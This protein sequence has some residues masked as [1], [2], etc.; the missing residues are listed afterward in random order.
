[1]GE[2]DP[3]FIQDV[4]HR[5]KL[6]VSQAEGIPLIDLTALAGYSP[7]DGAVAA[8]AAAAIEGLVAEIGEACKKWGFF[9]VVNHGV[10]AEKRERIEREARE[11]FGQDL[12]EKKKVRK[13]ERK[14]MGYYEMEHTKNVRDWREVFDITVQEPTLVPASL[15]D[16]E[17]AVIEW[18]NQWPEY[19]PGLREACEEYTQEMEKLAYKLMGLIAQSL[20]LPANRFGEFFKDQTSYLRLV[21]YPPCPAPHLALGLGRHNDLGALAILAQDD[22]GG[23]EVKR[24]SD[25]EWVLV[26]PI[27][28]AFIIN[29]GCVMQ[30]WSNDMYESVEHR[31]M[32]N[33]EKERFS[34]PF[35]FNPSHYTM[36]QPLKE[37]TDEHNPPKYR[38]YSWG[39]FYVIRKGGN[40]KKLDVENIQIHHFRI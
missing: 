24:K 14:V 35:F 16:G 39:R 19:P 8:S 22:V 5:P 1:M 40:F 31:V 29:V 21:R 2:V 12:E 33:T 15:K 27:P 25:G 38:P 4:E 13:D 32:V 34:I 26:K 6:A 7:S 3:A 11:F 23:L 20:G 9:T 36:V 28:D 17:E 37:L 18:T 10:A 30:V